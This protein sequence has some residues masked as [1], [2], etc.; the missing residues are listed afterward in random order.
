MLSAGKS[1]RRGQLSGGTPPVTPSIRQEA[2]GQKE[3][4]QV[5]REPQAGAEVPCASP[6]IPVTQASLTE[7]LFLSFT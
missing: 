2:S 4:G 7:H 6:C 5:A 1:L 3:G